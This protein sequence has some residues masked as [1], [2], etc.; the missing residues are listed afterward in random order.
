MRKYPF[1]TVHIDHKG[2]MN[3]MSDGKHHCL[4]V[5]DA[6]SGFV[7]VYPVRSTDATH[8][9]EAMSIFITYFGIPQKIVYDRRI[10]FMK[11]DLSNFLLD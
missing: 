2:P 7:Q 11:T 8:T 5:L 10:S 1:H 4:F 6:F 9:I 3:P